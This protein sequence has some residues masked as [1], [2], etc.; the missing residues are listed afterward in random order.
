MQ[1]T[2][3][4]HGLGKKKEFIHGARCSPRTERPSEAKPRLRSNSRRIMSALSSCELV[5]CKIPV[6][7]ALHHG[8]SRPNSVSL[9]MVLFVL[10]F[11]FSFNISMQL[12]SS[13][14]SVFFFIIYGLFLLQI[15]NQFPIVRFP[16]SF[17]FPFAKTI[18]LWLCYWC[19]SFSSS[20]YFF[21]WW[22]LKLCFKTWNFNL[23]SL[24]LDYSCFWMWTAL[25]LQKPFLICYHNL[26]THGILSLNVGFHPRFVAFFAL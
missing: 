6:A 26:E 19:V 15:Y 22:K 21:K 20:Y 23:L 1:S 2:Q 11:S 13:I 10:G 18:K 17:S 24:N 12:S 5:S 14:I 3:F 16:C 4:I 9:K 8:R 25:D 7:A